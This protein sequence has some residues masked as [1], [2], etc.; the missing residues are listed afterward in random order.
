MIRFW[1]LAISI[2][3]YISTFSQ[4]PVLFNA[5]EIIT[6]GKELY[7]SAKYKEAIAHYLAL[8]K[9]DTG[10]VYMLSEL[11]L[12]YIANEE[13]EKSLAVCEAGLK[14][15]S[16]YRVHFLRSQA[17]ATDRN[18]DYLKAVTLFNKAIEAY[19]IDFLLHYNLGITHYNH[20]A[21]DKAVDCFFKVL[22]LN[23]FHPGSHRNLGSISVGQGRKTHAMLSF[24]IY[25]G[26]NNIDNERLVFL[27]KFL[28]NQI[29]DEGSLP[30]TGPNAFDKLDQIIRA[31][32]AMD[33]NY[34]SKIDIDA[35]IVRQYQMFFDQ[36]ETVASSVDDPWSRYY[37]A[38][39]KTFKEKDL[40][41]P[42]IFHILK[43]ANIDQVKKW[44]QKNQKRLDAFYSVTNTELK[45]KRETIKVPELGFDAPTQAWFYT[46]NGVEAIGNEDAQ[47]VR[48]GKWIFFKTNCERSAEGMYSNK[49]K[50]SGTWKYF[51]ENGST[52]SI[53][54]FETGA[55]NVFKDG[56]ITQR[57]F[58]E[59]NE[60]QGKVELYN[61]CGILRESLQYDKGRRHGPGKMFYASG[62]TKSTYAYDSN[63]VVGEYINFFESGKI[64]NV[65]TYKQDK[66]DG[67][68]TENFANGKRK[69]VGEY[70]EDELTGL[71][72]YYHA[73]G[74]L[75]SSGNY[76]DGLTIGE[77]NFYDA[78]G[79]LSET[80][81]F[82]NAGNLHGE[83]TFYYNGKIY[84]VN[85]YKSDLLISVVYR[86]T[87][88]KEMGKFGHSSG[89][90]SVKQYYP[91]GQFAAE[92]FYKKG[93]YHGAWKYYF[94][95][96]SRRSEF[97][98]EDGLIQGEAA[99]YFKSGGKK[100]LFN[101][102]DGDYNGEF[103]EY[104]PHGQLKQT[105]WFARGARQQQW[106]SYYPSGVIESDYY[107]LH[108]DLLG[109]CLDYNSTGKLSAV[110][111]YDLQG[112]KNF[113]HY[114]AHGEVVTNRVEQTQQVNF[115]AKYKSGQPQSKLETTCGDYT[116]IIKWFPD[117]KV[118]Y[119]YTLLSGNKEGVYQFNSISG[120]PIL[121]GNY[122]DGREE[123]L[124]QKFYDNGELDYKGVYLTGE[125][126]STWVYHFPNG[127]IASTVDFINDERNGITRNFSPEGIP[128][129]EKLYFEGDL[130]AYRKINSAQKKAEEWSAF[131]PHTVIVVNYQD[132]TKAYEEVYKNGVLT[133]P[134]RIYYSNGNL[135]SEYLY[136]LGD[137]TGDYSIY[138]PNGKPMEKGTYKWGELDGTVE[139]YNEDG[140]LY[141][142]EQYVMGSRNGPAILYDK[143]QK[144]IEC[145][146]YAGLP[147][148]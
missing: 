109:L 91:T 122:V 32:I 126:D 57:F 53:E 9:R 68:Y 124:W 44:H 11:S 2:V 148:E 56:V 42:F 143:G 134:K 129:V 35:A 23:P 142:M 80:R 111:E 6:R 54:D 128:L 90:F 102:K 137:Y 74:R 89:A 20:K 117:G 49:G 18:G 130:V 63:K 139:K 78:R 51:H 131:T 19:P 47:G 132:G 48:K 25:L 41:E 3:V 106:L 46:N 71:W 112:V 108:G 119:T 101:Y 67:P 115:E 140:S 104:F 116:K 10:Y 72:K 45:K 38:L 52:S 98:Y 82:D 127:N 114:N 26:I 94:P 65:L 5:A 95:E 110:S 100:F 70:T 33:N 55:V 118:F 69:A 58:L 133:G 61:D 125:H 84:Y 120:K 34:K 92:G 146:F 15:A 79:N 138:Y 97:A 7:D 40:I 66:L 4:S 60:I 31:K 76:K 145:N 81:N 30:A 21:Y 103:K 29:S 28:A 24:G 75:E 59:N 13:Y 64:R 113:T 85:T 147:H 43:S 37:L 39:Y 107:Y 86:D 62:K 123:G 27:E 17:I 105:G 135:Y 1:L 50:K 16:F 73:N 36:L 121:Q 136:L 87:T 22:S 141:G 83:N 14:K 77:W 93:K 96:G 88:G 12:A 8:P 99:E 144:K